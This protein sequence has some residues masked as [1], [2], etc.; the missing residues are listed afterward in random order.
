[1]DRS[2][3]TVKN[4][5]TRQC[6]ESYCQTFI[7][8]K[9]TYCAQHDKARPRVGVRVRET[10]VAHALTA[11]GL[12]WSSWDKQLPESSC[13]RYRPDFLFELDT[14]VVVVEVD[15]YQHA[16]PG[17]SCDNARMLDIYGACGGLPV[18]FIRFNPDE[19]SLGGE[20]QTGPDFESRVAVLVDHARSALAV[21]PSHPLTI[22]R[23]YYDNAGT[24]VADNSWV[25]PAVPGFVEHS[26]AP[27]EIVQPCSSGIC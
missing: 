6:A 5:R 13:G 11:A 2:F 18:V 26:F 7:N 19:Y 16:R 21:P 22:T 3:S 27:I 10:L 17:Y 14:H 4:L 24:Q 23:L 15:E 8:Y 25:D 1:M 9:F 12:Q 20:P